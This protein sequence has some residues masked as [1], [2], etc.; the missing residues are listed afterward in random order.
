METVLTAATVACERVVL[1][2]STV[3]VAVI[4]VVTSFTV[5]MVMVLAEAVVVVVVVL[6]DDVCGII[7]LACAVLTRLDQHIH[8]SR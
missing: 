3:A 4:V 6:N 1:P 2:L 5:V 8:W 7:Q